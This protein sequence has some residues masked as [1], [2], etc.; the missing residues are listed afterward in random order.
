M[1]E[2]MT[3]R[4]Q[5]DFFAPFLHRNFRCYWVATMLYSAGKWTETV[6]LG[7]LVLQM[8]GSPWLVGVVAACRGVGYG[9]G[10]VFGALADRYN[11]RFLLRM[12]SSWNTVNTFILALIVTLGVA[13]Y[14]HVILIAVVAGLAHGFDLP[15]R[16]TFTS[17]LV[18]RRILTNA[19]A[20]IAVAT[21]LTAVL[22]PALAG[23][24]IGTIGVGGVSWI[25]A[26]IYLCN[27]GVLSSI[28]GSTTTA[29]G[30][31][32]PLWG[33]LKGG[34]RYILDHPPVFALLGMAVVVN[35]FQYPNRYVL[36]PVF[37][38]D[39]LKAGATGY[40]FLLAAS[41]MGALLGAGTMAYIGET[42][43]RAWLCITAC[44]CAGGAI[45]AFAWS[46][47]YPL[48][49]GLMGC[50]GLTEAIGSTTMASLL[51]FLTPN[52]MRGRVMGVRSLAILPMSLGNLLSGALAH[53]FGAPAA[54]TVNGTVQVLSILIIAGWVRSLR[55][56]G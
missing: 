1:P 43:G 35:L 11:R 31:Q 50:V 7:W 44:A 52:E 51:L 13:Q 15:L 19:V 27:V 17:D 38:R 2:S 39:V 6:V 20:L 53:H 32:G 18:E 8:T 36:V 45:V 29:R 41:G 9:L 33:N 40:G 21:D 37:A 54:C 28:Q 22:G 56:S 5:G 25:L 48:S 30:I 26:A 42:R 3:V 23:P 16:Y 46:R 12:I 34:G 55:K 49:V 14:W 10:P 24:L 4:R 47:S